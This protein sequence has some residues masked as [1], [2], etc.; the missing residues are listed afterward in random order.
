MVDAESLLNIQADIGAVAQCVEE[1]RG[2]LYR[3]EIEAGIWWLELSPPSAPHETFVVCLAWTVYPHQ[4]P[5]VKFADG[6]GGRLDRSDA[7]PIVPGYRPGNLDICRPIC[8]EGFN[9]HPEWRTSAESWKGTG[10][11]FLWVVETLIEDLTSR[12]G[13][14]SA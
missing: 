4:P 1:A 6:I 13:G 3:D 11:P 9:T 7:W 14:R 10:N 12:Y 2:R 8:V 5:S